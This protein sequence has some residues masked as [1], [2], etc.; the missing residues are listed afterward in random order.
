MASID[1]APA[2]PPAARNLRFELVPRGIFVLYQGL[3]TPSA[4]EWDRFVAQVRDYDADMRCLVYTEGWHPSRAQGSAI[5]AATRGKHPVVAIVSPASSVPFV[6]S[7]FTLVNRS[8][9]FFDPQQ[10]DA[11]LDHIRLS[12]EERQAV[13]ASLER[14]RR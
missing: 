7:V 11:A 1:S 3:G 9:R 10:L 5:R 2:R 13:L 4:G 6:V 14:L 12:P 8:M